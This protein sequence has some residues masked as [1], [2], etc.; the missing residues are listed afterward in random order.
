MAARILVVEDDG[1]VRGFLSRALESGGYVPVAVR[2]GEEALSL[3]HA[4]PPA[5]VLIDGILPDMHGVRLA[6]SV[7]ES[8]GGETIAICFVTGALRE[9][10]AA[11]AGVGAMCKPIRLAA[12]LDHVGGLLRWR[13]DGGSAVPQRREALRRLEQGFLVGP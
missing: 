1:T 3:L 13:D 12:L 9:N 5:A 6:E 4:D 8:P 10:I 7:L 2:T 11:V